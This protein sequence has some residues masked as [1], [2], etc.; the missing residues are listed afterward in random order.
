MNIVSPDFGQNQDLP[1]QFTCKGENV[2]PELNFEY[3]PPAA[4]SLVLIVEDAMSS[5]KLFHHWLIWNIDPE[6]THF[7]HGFVPEKS[8]E[9]RNGF[10]TIG[11]KGPCLEKEKHRIV[12]R[13]YALKE[14]LS[15]SKEASRADINHAMAALILKQAE[16][17]CFAGDWFH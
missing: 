14:K 17:M 1:L 6:I 12:F 11:Y 8:V 5:P 4:K 2:S 16:L 13:L 10:G 9:G 7:P 3:V 15:L